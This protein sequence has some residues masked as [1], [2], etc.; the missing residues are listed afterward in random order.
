MISRVLIHNLV[1][2]NGFQVFRLTI[3]GK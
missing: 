1:K 2:K 3:I